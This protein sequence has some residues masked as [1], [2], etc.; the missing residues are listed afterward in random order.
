MRPHFTFLLQFRDIAKTVTR[1]LDKEETTLHPPAASVED[2]IRQVR[3]KTTLSSS[4]LSPD[5]NQQLAIEAQQT[6]SNHQQPPMN[7]TTPSHAPEAL[8]SQQTASSHVRI[9]TAAFAEGKSC[10]CLQGSNCVCLEYKCTNPCA[11]WLVS[12]NPFI[13]L[14]FI[15]LPLFFFGDFVKQD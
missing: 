5:P 12:D 2:A 6:S 14:K 3:V 8:P 10:I 4:P 7:G 11:G 9:T 1:E 13:A 15:T